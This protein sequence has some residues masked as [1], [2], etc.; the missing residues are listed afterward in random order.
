MVYRQGDRRTKYLV[1]TPLADR[2]FERMGELMRL[3]FA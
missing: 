2:Y 1:T 3:V